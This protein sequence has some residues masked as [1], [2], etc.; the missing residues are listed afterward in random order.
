M[1]KD[2]EDKGTYS[3]FSYGANLRRGVGDPAKAAEAGHHTRDVVLKIVQEAAEDG[4]DMSSTEI[5]RE[6]MNRRKGLFKGSKDLRTVQGQVNRILNH[7][8]YTGDVERHE[9]NREERRARGY[10][11]GRMG[12]AWRAAGTQQH[13][14]ET[15][16]SASE[17]WLR[18]QRDKAPENYGPP[19]EKPERGYS[20]ANPD[21]KPD[22]FERQAQKAKERN[23]RERDKAPE[24]QGRQ[25][26]GR[27]G[28][29]KAPKG[30]TFVEK[31]R[32]Q[33]DEGLDAQ[34]DKAPENQG[35][36]GGQ[37][38]PP[39]GGMWSTPPDKW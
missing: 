39:K 9:L 14:P 12:V 24:N 35:R 36:Q 1:S 27:G 33:H 37:G 28:S 2:E 8:N 13:T 11:S 23:E 30:E 17:E 25:G 3:D 19:D 32:R 7:L 4:A 22:W 10:P 29:G 18:R 21:K 5:A 38:K 20:R 31:Q 16:G 6:L 15:H 34:R 26:R